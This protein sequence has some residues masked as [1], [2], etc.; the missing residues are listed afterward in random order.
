M[1][2]DLLS[3]LSRWSMPVILV[4]IPLYGLLRGV[5]VYG[6]FVEGAEEGFYLAVRIL[7]YMLAI[8]VALEVFRAAGALALVVNS[9]SPVTSSL[10]VPGEMVPLVLI[11]PLSGSGALGVTAELLREWGPDSFIGKMACTLQGS[12]DTTFFILTI[13]F[14]S[15]NIRKTR[16]CLPVALLGDLAGFSTA[17]FICNKFF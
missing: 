10:G 3:S 8:F 5:D 9:L 4:V 11:R 12:T 7:P 2:L 13:Y 6:A 1:F 14:G 15:V 17:I 16:H